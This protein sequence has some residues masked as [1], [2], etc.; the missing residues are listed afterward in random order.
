MYYD[1]A[2][3]LYT[4]M[5]FLDLVSIRSKKRPDFSLQ[6]R[7]VYMFSLLHKVEEEL[8]KDACVFKGKF[9]LKMLV[10]CPNPVNKLKHNNYYDSFFIK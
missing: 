4:I 6:L 3:T 7:N 5:N 9:Y 1:G 2:R 8:E 10:R